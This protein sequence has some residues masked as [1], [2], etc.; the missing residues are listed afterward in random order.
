MSAGNR[1]CRWR[2]SQA[3]CCSTHSSFGSTL[4][5]IAC[6]SRRDGRTC[7][8]YRAQLR[9]H[10]IVERVAVGSR[11]PPAAGSALV[12]SSPSPAG[13][14]MRGRR[15]GYFVAAAAL[16]LGLFALFN[17]VESGTFMGPHISANLAPLLDDWARV[18]LQRGALWFW[19]GS[20]TVGGW[21]SRVDLEL[22]CHAGQPE[23]TTGASGRALRGGDPGGGGVPSGAYA[24]E[25]LWNCWP[26]GL[27]LFVPS[28]RFR[29]LAPA[30]VAHRCSRSSRCGCRRHMMAALSGDPGSC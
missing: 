29:E 30:V 9:T 7:S 10:L 5:A 18:R 6:L 1:G 4:P 22:G 20:S 24:R 19:P 25:S 8:P 27:L 28:S 23:F 2:S 11:N 17:L 21:R 15:L 16:I 26:A 13:R 12:T 14:S 3:P